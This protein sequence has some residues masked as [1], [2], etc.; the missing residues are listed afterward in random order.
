[1]NKGKIIENSTVD[2]LMKDGKEFY[3]FF[4]IEAH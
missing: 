3:H 2:D 1:M 4:D